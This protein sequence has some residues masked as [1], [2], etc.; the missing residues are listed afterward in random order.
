V[1][2]AHP[3]LD[4]ANVIE[5]VVATAKPVD[6]RTDSPIYGHGLIDANAAVTAEVAAVSANPMGDLAEWVRLHRRGAA[7]A[8]P[9]APE[10]ATPLP[11]PGADAGEARSAPIWDGP[12]WRDTVIPL[13]TIVGFVTLGV[14][15][16]IAATRHFKRA[17]R[18]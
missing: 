1:R 2:A 7:A 12:V 9:G 17:L 13:T 18:K 5:R 8:E 16:V 6:G 15:G 10:A 11:L 3:D 4:A 14:L